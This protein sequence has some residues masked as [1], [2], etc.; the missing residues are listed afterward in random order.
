M[1]A[2]VTSPQPAV[3][4][5]ANIERETTIIES[6]DDAAALTIRSGMTVQEMERTLII[7]TLKSTSDNRTQAAK[8]LGI[9][10][11]T[12]R[13]KMHE[14]RMGSAEDGGDAGEGPEG[15]ELGE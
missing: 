15:L 1:Q 13:N 12:L 4:L 6:S 5:A 14:Y 2:A 7:E 3:G 9:S 8:L 11:R 10:I